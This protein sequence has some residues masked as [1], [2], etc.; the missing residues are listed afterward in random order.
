MRSTNV[1]RQSF[2]PYARLE[3][4]FPRLVRKGLDTWL[5][6][7]RRAEDRR[8]LREMPADLWRDIGVDRLQL[9]QEA[10]KPF[11]RA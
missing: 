7:Q 8:R 3:S 6:W 10:Q 5:L 4:S 1:S 2:A 11:W 9:E